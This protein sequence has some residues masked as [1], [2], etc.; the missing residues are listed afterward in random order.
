MGQ[1]STMFRDIWRDY[2]TN[3]VQ[4]S[5]LHRPEKGEIRELGDLIDEQIE[6]AAAGQVAAETWVAL[7]AISGTRV[8]QPAYVPRTDVGTHTDPVVGG[9]VDNQGSYRWVTD[10]PGGWKRIDDYPDL[11][12]IQASTGVPDA[13]KAIATD[14]NGRLDTTF[15]PTTLSTAEDEKMPDSGGDGIR[16]LTGVN[17]TLKAEQIGP[18][19]SEI[20]DLAGQ[21]R[22][23]PKIYLMGD[24]R[25]DL[26]SGEY[27][28]ETRGWLWWL[29]VGTGWRFDFQL[30]QNYGSG[31]T[32]VYEIQDQA[33]TIQALE[34]GIVC[35][36]EETNDRTDS[37][38]TNAINS[39]QGLAVHQNIITSKHTLIWFTDTPRGDG[40]GG[41]L[42]GGDLEYHLRV[43]QWFREQRG[44]KGV[45]V[46]DTWPTLVDK[47]SS[48]LVAENGNYYD[49]LHPG[50]PAARKIA[51]CAQ[52]IIEHL[53]P[54]RPLLP[55]T[56]YDTYTA[57]N[58]SGNLLDNGM[59]AGTAGTVGANCTGV[60]A[61]G[62]VS[63][64]GTGLSAA[65]SKGTDADGYDEQIIA[66]TGTPSGA[67]SGSSTLVDPLN[68]DVVSCVLTYTLTDADLA[69]EDV[70]EAV[71]R[72]KV[73]SGS[74]GL[75]GVPLYII[76]AGTGVDNIVCGGEPNM[77]SN[78]SFPNLRFP[79][80]EIE[81]PN[82]TPEF[83]VPAGYTALGTAKSVKVK[84]CVTA[85]G[86]EAITATV[87]I[88][89]VAARKVRS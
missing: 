11:N 6:G 26:C 1:I 15:L 59:M 82:M 44:V 55:F 3:G 80:V 19:A 78:G 40:T 72:F 42:T 70:L 87:R 49:Q 88:G 64:A 30:N 9:T 45:Y 46:A 66:I 74:S 22:L 68:V 4:S 21:P 33:V 43:S 12:P 27:Q 35:G 61:D 29:G 54:E 57:N 51:L 85:R 84:I 63:A 48:S 31:G 37:L 53:L 76:S 13:D 17:D 24:S 28:T 56:N 89:R 39:Y 67:S 14:G 50:P 7:A 83:T 41:A 58:T 65:L 20:S 18:W 2:V 38:A 5:G 25:C 71:N 81:G 34:P 86:S 10:S 79:N 23:R 52:P 60:L 62:W 77:A 36:F 69:D 47:T 32:E 8:G 73:D 75:R 16:A